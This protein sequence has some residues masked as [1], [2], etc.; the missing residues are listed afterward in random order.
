MKRVVVRAR[1]P[2][3]PSPNRPGGVRT[4]LLALLAAVAAL[5]G[6][7][8]AGVPSS[9]YEWMATAPIVIVGSVAV[10]DQRYVEFEATTVLRGE[11]PI[12]GR[13]AVDVRSANRDRAPENDRL[14]PRIGLRYL[15]LLEP[16]EARKKRATSLHRLVHGVAGAREIPAEGGQ[17]FLDAV[18]RMVAVQE[19]KD[20][21]RTW[22]A[23]EGML[24]D[25]NPLLVRTA[26]DLYEKFRRATPVHLPLLRPLLDHPDPAL[27][28][29]SMRLIAQVQSTR[30]P[31]PEEDRV[32]LVGELASRARRDA[33]IEVRVAATA[34]LAAF[35]GSHVED[36]LREVAREDPEQAVRFE[37]QKSLFERNGGE[38][39]R[40]RQD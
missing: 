17:A 5:S 2:S 31:L 24:E 7:V 32:I 21:G 3:S 20:D 27:R 30:G 39:S 9:T 6:V 4:L 16:V 28:A 1:R 26:L 34:A 29:G 33:V 25:T 15:L 40:P 18:R 11:V 13:V 12:G 37:A 38:A 35:P 23:L 10:D 14:A 8:S 22:Q 19:I 36:L